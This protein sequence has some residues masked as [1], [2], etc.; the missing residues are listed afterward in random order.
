ARQQR[1]SEIKQNIFRLSE[2]LDTENALL[3]ELEA[4]KNLL[5]Q[6]KAN[7]LKVLQDVQKD[8]EGISQGITTIKSQHHDRA[9]Q[10]ANLRDTTYAPLKDEVDT[11]REKLGL[12]KLPSLQDEME[13]QM[14]KRTAATMDRNRHYQFEFYTQ[15]F[16]LNHTPIIII[17]RRF[18]FENRYQEKER[19]TIINNIIRKWFQ[20]I[21]TITS[22]LNIQKNKSNI[23]DQFRCGSNTHSSSSI[24]T[25]ISIVIINRVSIYKCTSGSTSGCPFDKVTPLCVII[26]DG[27]GSR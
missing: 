2:Q 26:E 21:I 12:P 6:E 3:Q 23:Q 27:R 13:S 7:L 25:I 11:E 17:R 14:S 20:T 24:I 22:R 9:A 5:Q 19:E 1:L 8:I 10:L 16:E 15:C 4:E 18:F